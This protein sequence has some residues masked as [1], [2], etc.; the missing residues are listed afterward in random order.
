M[1]RELY[2]Q[3]FHLN[4]NEIDLVS[5]LAPKRQMLIKN[6]DV[7][8]V[9]N[10]DVDPKSYWIYTNDPFDNRKRREAFEA[11]GFEKGLEILA[12]GK[13]ETPFPRPRDRRSSRSSPAP[14]TWRASFGSTWKSLP[15]T[16]SNRFSS[17]SFWASFS[18]RWFS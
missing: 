5:T 2:G 6:P 18:R 13:D 15:S 12:G 3:Q 9:A 4:D 7:A 10:L 8:K 14:S 17:A 16:G 11:Y 1:D